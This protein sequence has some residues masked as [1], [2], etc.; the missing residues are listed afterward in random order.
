MA[1]L[2]NSASCGSEVTDRMEEEQPSSPP[3]SGDS[4]SCFNQDVDFDSRLDRCILRV[5]EL[6]K[7][8]QRALNEPRMPLLLAQG[9]CTAE[10]ALVTANVGTVVVNSKETGQGA[11]DLLRM[12]EV[13]TAQLPLLKLS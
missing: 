13:K 7:E 8:A 11:V 3:I 9:A 2:Q 4:E 6:L 10:T 12:Q 1:G 5:Q